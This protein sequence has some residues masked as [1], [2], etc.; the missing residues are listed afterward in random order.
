MYFFLHNH[1]VGQ[2]R[3]TQM[4]WLTPQQTARGATICLLLA[5]IL[6]L[7]LS[8]LN[9][10]DDTGVRRI[11]TW[12][13]IML[14]IT[15]S[16]MFNAVAYTGGPY[17]L[18][19]IG[20]AHISIGYAGLGDLFVFLYFG[21]V[22]TMTVPYL[23]LHS[24]I[25]SSSSSIDLILHHPLMHRSFH[26]ALPIGFLATAIIVV[27]NLRDRKTD[28]VAKKMTLA[29]RLGESFARNEYIFLLGSSYLLLLPLAIVHS[30]SWIIVLLPFL[31]LPLAIPQ[32]KAVGFGGKDGK[33]LNEHVGGTA[34]VQLFFCITLALAIRNGY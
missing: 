27:N 5:M 15:F 12:D 19:Y 6:G 30:F 11:E 21:L 4:G 9:V 2:P 7:H 16:S 3:A 13:G 31:T 23:Y 20:L 28:V 8:R 18:G 26:L 32:L 1:Q 22:A 25:S 17:P 14:F 24:F 29:V 33:A 10:L 34:R